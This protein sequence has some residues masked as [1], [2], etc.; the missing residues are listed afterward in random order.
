MA[1]F[2]LL[3]QLAHAT[4]ETDETPPAELERRVVDRIRAACPEVEW[5]GSYAVLGPY[6]YLDV[7]RAPDVETAIEVATIVRRL[8]HARAEVWGA[9][10]WPRFKELA[11]DA[12][13]APGG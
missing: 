11:R 5:A 4:P 1:T 10:E 12:L 8:G 6:D 3:T 7:F 9:T 2:I 13:G